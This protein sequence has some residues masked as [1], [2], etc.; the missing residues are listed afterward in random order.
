AMLLRLPSGRSLLIDA[1]G[2]PGRFDIGDRILVPALLARGALALDTVVLTHPD[3]DHIGGAA[4][5]IDDLHPR[6]VIEGVAPAAHAER[7]ALVSRALARGIAVESVRRGSDLLIDGVLLRV[8]HPSPP[9]WE[10]QKTRNDD[11]VV[12]EVVF[13]SVSLVLTGDAGEPV[14][15]GIAAQLAPA[16]LRIL[17]VG[18]HGSR[19]STSERFLEAVG[20][21]AAVISAGRGNFYGHPA[22]EVLRRLGRARV[23]V[24][25]TDRDGQIDIVTDGKVTEIRT[26]S[27]RRW[28]VAAR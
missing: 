10:R 16:R 18:H 22:P 14:E 23:E 21:S 9:D 26:W 7:H 1:A 13:G 17:K 5:V 28:A 20:A 15:A 24:F 6:R 19:T 8:L 12:I 25:R 4:R 2:A 11:S 27:G 3:A